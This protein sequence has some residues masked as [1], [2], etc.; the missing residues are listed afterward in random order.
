MSGSL[1]EFFLFYGKIPMKYRIVGKR[2]TPIKCVLEIF[3]IIGNSPMDVDT[4]S[5]NIPK[6][7]VNI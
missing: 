3:V 4:K 1:R 2:R 5:I 7:P 6:I